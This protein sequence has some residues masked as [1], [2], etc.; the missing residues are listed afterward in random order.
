M[1]VAV[2]VV[3]AEVHG[4]CPDFFDVGNT[5][6][7]DMILCW[8]LVVLST[9][10]CM[11]R[12]E[13]FPAEGAPIGSDDQTSPEANL[14]T[15]QTTLGSVLLTF[16]NKGRPRQSCHMMERGSVCRSLLY[17]CAYDYL[18]KSNIGRGGLRKIR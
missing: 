8:R 15:I 13:T 7:R 11:E 10:V 6:S 2:V 3:E 16:V 5:V 14:R 18:R 4:S 12:W 1:M 9:S 17:C